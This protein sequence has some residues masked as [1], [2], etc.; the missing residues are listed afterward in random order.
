MLAL[1]THLQDAAARA[2]GDAALE[3]AEI[4][5]DERSRLAGRDRLPT[6]AEHADQQGLHGAGAGRLR[7]DLEIVAL[8]RE[9][10]RR[11]RFRLG[12]GPGFRPQLLVLRQRQDHL[13]GGGVRRP[14]TQERGGGQGR[15]AR[16]CSG[17][18]GHRFHPPTAD[19]PPPRGWT[20]LRRSSSGRP[21]ECRRAL[22][23]AA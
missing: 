17:P 3:A 10:S 20:E 12:R 8:D 1:A 18:A 15:R 16:P 14:R 7:D 13:P 19:P 5:A 22:G 11:R 9:R 2:F 23:Q 21:V 4:G 6:G